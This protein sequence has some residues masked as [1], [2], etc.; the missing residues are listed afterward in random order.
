MTQSA[1]TLEKREDGVAVLT[2]DV[3]GE[4]MNTL[5]EAFGNEITAMLDDIEHV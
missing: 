5:K 3:P 2:M 1:F 4:S